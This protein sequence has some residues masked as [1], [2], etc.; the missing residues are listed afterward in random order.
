MAGR[1]EVGAEEV[2]ARRG[3]PLGQSGCGERC[4]SRFERVVEQVAVGEVLEQVPVGVA[5]V[6]E[7]LAAL[8]M[9]ADSPG[10]EI[11]T[12][13]QVFAAGGQGVKVTDL[14]RRVD[15]AVGRTQCER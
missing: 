8:N 4:P 3:S 11:A 6:V 10:A 13:A 9:S 7:D 5:P 15:V 2:P 12:L 1:F 14:I